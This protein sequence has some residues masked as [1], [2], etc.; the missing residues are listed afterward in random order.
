MRRLTVV[1]LVPALSSGGVERATLE[2]AEALVA[3]GHHSVV[4]SG[5]GRLVE[6]LQAAGS[7]HISLEIGGKSPRTLRHVAA[8]R[9]LFAN[10][11][12]DIVHAR[13]RLP[14]WIG[15]LALKGVRS[16]HPHFVTTVHG[17]NSPGAYSGILTRGERVICVSETVRRHV[18]RHW[19]RTDPARVVVIERGVD[20]RQFAPREVPPGGAARPLLLMPARGTRLKGHATAIELLAAVRAA[21]VDARL[22]L[23]GARQA[24]RESYLAEL[25]QRASSLGVGQYLEITPPTESI[26]DAYRRSDLVLQLSSQSEAFGRTVVEALSTGTPVVGWA[27]GGVGE[28]LARHFPEGAVEAGN[29]DALLAT[30]LRFLAQPPRVG[31]IHP[32]TL[33]EMQAQTLKLYESIAG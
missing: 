24:G 25:E 14:A 10:L 20:P 26:A 2:I 27:R 28:L 30:T 19:P 6:G 7:T 1:Q 31:T 33:A 16:R 21:G 8:L 11:A 5:G 18:L 4:V 23:L 32:Q 12:P 13:S 15:W 29:V 17:L 22:C 3:A 9:R